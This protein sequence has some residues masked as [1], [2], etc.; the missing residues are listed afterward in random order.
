MGDAELVWLLR[1]NEKHI[2]VNA[3]P[4]C[5]V[6]STRDF[7]KNWAETVLLPA[8]AG[9][10]G[11]SVDIERGHWEADQYTPTD[12]VWRGVRIHS[13]QTVFIFINLTRVN[14]DSFYQEGIRSETDAPYKET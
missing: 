12:L 9:N 1:T 8:L 14:S 6:F 7:A 2:T 10:G 4:R 5:K 11:D 3:S 13:N